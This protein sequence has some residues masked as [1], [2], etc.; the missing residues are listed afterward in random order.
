MRIGVRCRIDLVGRSRLSSG[1][2]TIQAR[3]AP[4]AFRHDAL[5]H[6]AHLRRRKLLDHAARSLW[7]PGRQ[8]HRGVEGLGPQPRIALHLIGRLQQHMRRHIDTAICDRRHHRHQ[9]HWS[10]GDLL[11]NRHRQDAGRPPFV[12]RPEQSASLGR[13]LDPRPFAKP[14]TA[15][16]RVK[17][18]RSHLQRHLRR[19]YIARVLQRILHRHAAKVVGFIIMQRPPVHRHRAILTVNNVR[20]L[21]AG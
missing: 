4:G 8:L 11:P 19:P 14:K 10:H 18:F 5:H 15:H 3:K 13:Q 6:G 12:R 1:T 16:V 7:Q 21:H 17:L 2:V 9:L 20:R